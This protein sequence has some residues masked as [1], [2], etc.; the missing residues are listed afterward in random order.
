M[1]K[2]Q[3]FKIRK[4]EKEDIPLILQMIRE[5][6]SYEKLL[7]KHSIRKSFF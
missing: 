6:A 2:K 7:R 4:A 5:L 3:S 1:N